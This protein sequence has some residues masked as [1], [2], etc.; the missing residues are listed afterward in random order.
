MNGIV[1]ISKTMVIHGN[2]ETTDDL[3][4]EG[5]VVGNVTYE[6]D[7][8]LLGKVNG[9]IISTGDSESK[10]ELCEDA[11]VIGNMTGKDIYFAG[12]GEGNVLAKEQIHVAT[13][14]KIKGNIDAVSLEVENGAAIEG[15]IKINPT[16]RDL[17][18]IF[19]EL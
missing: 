11:V 6:R 3:A 9:D 18:Q 8:L 5:A 16:G 17:N 7:L 1:N 19:E 2:I 15:R 14:A 12:A 4:I 13:T 10:F